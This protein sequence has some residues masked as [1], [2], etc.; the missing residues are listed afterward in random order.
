MMCQRIGSPPI[1]TIGLGLTSVS[2]DN[3]LPV[4]PARIATCMGAT[5]SL[6]VVSATRGTRRDHG[7]EGIEVEQGDALV[8]PASPDEATR[9]RPHDPQVPP[10]RPGCNVG[11]VQT[12]QLFEGQVIAA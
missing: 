12:A 4:P 5:A 6:L 11:V 3:R 8:R 2:S 1:S 9:G 7:G 10:Q